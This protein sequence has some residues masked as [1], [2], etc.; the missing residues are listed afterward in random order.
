MTAPDEQEEQM[1]GIV[2]RDQALR[3]RVRAE[4]R[5]RPDTAV[6]QV[7]GLIADAWVRGRRQGMTEG[8][9]P[10]LDGLHPDGVTA[11]EFAASSQE[12]RHELVEQLFARP[13]RWGPYHP[14]NR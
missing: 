9:Q 4:I 8:S 13:Y 12:A 2:Y 7:M 6:N 1:A 10:L 3:D 14:E 5:K 11:A